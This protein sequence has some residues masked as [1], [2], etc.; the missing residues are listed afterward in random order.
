MGPTRSSPPLFS[1]FRR[2]GPPPDLFEVVERPAGGSWA[3]CPGF[4]NVLSNVNYLERRN[5]GKLPMQRRSA[6][7]K[8][9]MAP[10][11]ERRNLGKLPMQRRSELG[12]L[13]GTF[14]RTPIYERRGLGYCKCNSGKGEVLNKAATADVPDVFFIYGLTRLF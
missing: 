10:I 12:K 11:L 6:L 3:I 14:I 9:L 7:G 1:T 2:F 8:F 13:P 4:H 5:L